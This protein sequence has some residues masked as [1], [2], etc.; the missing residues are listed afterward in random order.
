MKSTLNTGFQELEWHEMHTTSTHG[1]IT[2]TI[3][4]LKLALSLTY[5]PTPGPGFPMME[6]FIASAHSNS[7]GVYTDLIVLWKT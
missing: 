2:Q 3:C 4:L 6:K 1:A 7:K 5:T